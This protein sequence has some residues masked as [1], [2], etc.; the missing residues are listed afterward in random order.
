[1]SSSALHPQAENKAGPSSIGTELEFFVAV[2]IDDGSQPTV[3]KLFASS[4]GK[5]LVVREAGSRGRALETYAIEHV[6]HTITLAIEKNVR[7]K[8]R[9]IASPQDL[10]DHE[11][12]HLGPY[13]SW[14]VEHEG[15]ASM[16]EDIL[17]QRGVSDYMWVDLEVKSPALWV[18]DDAFIKILDVVQALQHTYWICTPPSTALQFHYG[19]G[20]DY[21]PFRNLR[22]IAALLYAADPLVTQL[23]PQHRRN[24]TYSLSNRLYSIL[25]HGST[26]PDANRDPEAPETELESP[27]RR[28]EGSDPQR[29]AKV[30]GSTKFKPVFAHGMLT[31][32]DISAHNFYLTDPDTTVSLGSGRVPRGYACKPL[33]I[34]TAVREIL[35][36]TTAPGLSER[37]EILMERPAYDFGAYADSRYMREA[38]RRRQQPKRTIE[39]RH[40]AGTMDPEEVVAHTKI[41]VRFCEWASAADL[42][43]FWKLILDCEAG[44][45][46]PSWF[47]V[48]DLLARLDLN[49]EA[50]VLQTSMAPRYGIKILDEDAG[51]AKYPETLDPKAWNWDRRTIM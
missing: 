16:P 10:D 25:A 6:R 50:K 5:P 35:H 11:A 39:F 46:T 26:E 22:R 7:C 34:L 15:T 18:T 36:C 2:R 9:V 41:V 49:A 24:N 3:P 14:T 13:M 31:G 44:E 32:Y 8:T 45:S 40:A 33:G 21:I 38:P 37:M 43:E 17:G 48:F 4:E 1:M 12:R 47:D 27:D 30:Q 20:K 19:C 28:G 23:H 42:A 51:T 29:E